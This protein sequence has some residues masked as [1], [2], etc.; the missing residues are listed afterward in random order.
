MNG[1]VT[2]RETN[3]CGFCPSHRKI[4][5]TPGSSTANRKVTVH[6]TWRFSQDLMIHQ[7]FSER[8]EKTGERL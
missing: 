5:G 8:T 7:I 1:M 6:G 2:F 4:R 3:G